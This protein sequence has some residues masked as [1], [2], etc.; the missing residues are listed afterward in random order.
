MTFVTGQDAPAKVKAPAKVLGTGPVK[1]REEE[2]ANTMS[3]NIVCGLDI[4]RLFDLGIWSAD[5]MKE[6]Q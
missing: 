2:I 6:D 5:E 4:E 3:K 1:V